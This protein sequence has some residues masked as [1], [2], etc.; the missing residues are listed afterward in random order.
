MMPFWCAYFVTRKKNYLFT[1]E[2]RYQFKQ[3]KLLI[4]LYINITYAF[5]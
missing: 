4:D 1:P 3:F 2:S 5:V